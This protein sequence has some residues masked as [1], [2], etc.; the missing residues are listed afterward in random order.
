[1]FWYGFSTPL[2]LPR[3]QNFSYDYEIFMWTF[4]RSGGVGGCYGTHFDSQSVIDAKNNRDL[5]LLKLDS[6]EGCAPNWNEE[7]FIDMA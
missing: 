6:V 3:E 2:P 1:L 7:V 5:C 4:F